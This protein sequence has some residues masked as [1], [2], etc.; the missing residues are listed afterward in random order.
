MSKPRLLD[1]VRTLHLSIADRGLP[2]HIA[3]YGHSV[4]A[5]QFP[6]LEECLG[7]L[8]AL[9]YKFCAP[10]ELFVE[11]AARKVSLSFDDNYRAWHPM[12]RIW[13]KLHIRATFYVNS[14][15]LRD[16][17]T[18]QQIDDYFDR[19]QHHGERS[20]LSVQEL[21][22]IAA[23]GHTIGSHAHSHCRLTGIEYAAAVEDIRKGKH[24][25]ED[26]LQGPV[27]DFSFPFGMRRHFSSRLRS[28][29]VGLGFRT[30]ASA[31]PGMQHGRRRSP[32]LHRTKWDFDSPLEF[33]IANLRIDGRVFAA[34]TGR[35]PIG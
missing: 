25:L 35:S 2:C 10:C 7:H 27:S 6:A 31:I 22:E 1:A 3:I 17:A 26:I 13:D 15:P 16:R 28:Y 34:L 33:N 20:P 24:I 14:L 9:G 23:A 4:E 32:Y 5:E 12:L 19:I 11:D 30:I 21:R 8:T 29:C 18:R